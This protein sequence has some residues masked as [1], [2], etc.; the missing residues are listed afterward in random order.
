[1]DSAGLKLFI[2]FD[3]IAVRFKKLDDYLC[4]RN[5][6]TL[7]S[8]RFSGQQ[9]LDGIPAKHNLN[10][11]Y[12]LDPS[13]LEIGSIHVVCPNGDKPYWVIDLHE[14]GYECKSIDLFEQGGKDNKG[15]ADDEPRRA[16]WRRKES[17]VI[18]PFDR[19]GKSGA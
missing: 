9:E 1:M 12:V 2:F 5:Q 6:P 14:G 13:E 16:R 18:V 4:T 17:G 3:V 7:Q 8:E 19:H 11:G 15:A 10:A